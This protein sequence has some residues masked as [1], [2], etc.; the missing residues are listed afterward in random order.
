[1]NIK[2]KLDFFSHLIQCNHNLP[3]H[4]YKPELILARSGIQQDASLSDD[5]TLVLLSLLEPI[6]RHLQNQKRN[7]LFIDDHL[8]L[9]W[10][11]AFEYEKKT[12]RAFIRWDLLIPAEILTRTSKRSWISVTSP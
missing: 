8:G 11:V 1:M 3:L 12:C 4:S 5:D 7:P 2:E 10:I 9:I 6:K